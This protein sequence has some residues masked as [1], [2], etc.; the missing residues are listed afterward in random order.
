M[1]IAINTLSLNKTKAGM[2]NYII[3]L[4]NNLA[5]IDKKN[6]YHVFV[7]EN[8]K[9]FF[10]IKQGNFKIINIGRIIRINLARLV[11]EQVFLPAY[12]KRH[13]ID[14]LH[15]PGFVIPFLSKAKNVLTIADMTFINYPKVHTIVKRAYF[16]LFMPYSMRKADRIISISGSTKRDAL[17]LI[18]INPDKIEV[19]HLAPEEGFRVIDRK[20]AES[21]IKLD[22]KIYSPFILFVGMIEPRKNLIRVLNSFSEL[23]KGLKKEKFPHKLVIVGKKGWK[24][25]GIFETVERLSLKKDV[26]FTGYIPDADLAMFYNAADIFVYPC[27]YEGFGLP[28]LEAMACGCPVITSDV[29]SMPEVAGNA[30][31]LVNPK[32]AHKISSAIGRLIKDR[33]LREDMIKKGL[34]RSREFSW[35]RCARETLKAYEE[36]GGA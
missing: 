33:K 19:T 26:V 31:L 14:V 11:W 36:V 22:Y 16:G 8:N 5:H 3:N 28:I 32:D 17:K 10:N 2:G 6:E 29:S 18:N 34:K 15:S 35:R 25:R 23:K 9:H 21:R 4:V 20:K 24:Y 13:K 7:S 12:V 30:A 27:L 1:R